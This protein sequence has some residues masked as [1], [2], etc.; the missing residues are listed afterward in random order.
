[1]CI[2]GEIVA[3]INKSAQRLAVSSMRPTDKRRS[4]DSGAR[5]V[6]RGGQ[7]DRVPRAVWSVAGICVATRSENLM[8][9]AF[10]GL[11]TTE[12]K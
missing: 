11:E 2:H 9:T 6:M 10:A 5:S 7:C 4:Q 3:G 8:S 12:G 1:L